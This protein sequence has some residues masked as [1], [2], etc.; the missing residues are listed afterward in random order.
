MQSTLPATKKIL[1]N[2]KHKDT[3]LWQDFYR[4][5]ITFNDGYQT[6]LDEPMAKEVAKACNAIERLLE[7]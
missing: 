1:N 3:Y 7:E 4:K 5:K 2:K 6:V